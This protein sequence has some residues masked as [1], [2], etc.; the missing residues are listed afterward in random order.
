MR[1][2]PLLL[3]RNHP[4][5]PQPLTEIYEDALE[6]CIVAERLGF[7]FCLVAE[8]H[9]AIDQ[10]APSPLTLLAAMAARTERIRLGTGVLQ[11]AFH[12][13]VR[14]AEDI[15]SIDLISKRALRARRR[16][17]LRPG[18]ARGHRR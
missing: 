7:D 17:R 11:L 14:V 10:W 18:G 9:F 12:D 6:D 4:E 16:H 1:A 8:H 2:G 13:P 5:R 15:A 3:I